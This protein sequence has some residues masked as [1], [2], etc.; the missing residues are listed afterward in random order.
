L[1]HR[2]ILSTLVLS[3]ALITCSNMPSSARGGGGGHSFGGGGHSWGSGGSSFGS[4][5]SS[6]WGSGGSSRPAPAASSSGSG[7]GT[8]RNSQSTAKSSAA[9]QALYAKAKMQGTVYNSR[10]EAVSAFRTK[11]ANDYKTTFS[12]EPSKRPDYIPGMT[13]IGGR[14]VPVQYD[15]RYGGYGYYDNG[16]WHAYEVFR[17]MAMLGLLMRNDHYVYGPSPYGGY[18]GQPYYPPQQHFPWGFVILVVLVIGVVLLV[19]SAKNAATN[20]MPFGEEVAPT[21]NFYQPRENAGFGGAAAPDSHSSDVND[22]EFWQEIAPGSIITLKDEQTIEDSMKKNLGAKPIDYIVSKVRRIEEQDG[23]VQWTLC[24]LKDPD[25]RIWFMAKSVDRNIDFRAYYE[26][27][28]F[29]P[30]NRRDMVENGNLWLFQEPRDVNNYKLSELEFTTAID[31]ETEVHGSTRQVSYEQKSQGVL[32]G[33]MTS[34]PA[35]T[36]FE[37]GVFT[38][39]AEY[40]TGDSAVQNPELLLLEMGGEAGSNGGLINLLLGASLTATDFEVVKR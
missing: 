22:P 36:G 37:R 6:G 19:K 5:R 26:P 14:D 20:R 24:L 4:G 39:V 27:D 30:G 11:H 31:R 18:P 9:D 34:D 2:L 7:W 35:E 3:A 10:E 21:G 29:R 38:A 40:V 12:S 1:N 33:S 13:Q 23:M 32:Y 16:R 25:Q 15:S 8:G 28:E 17:D